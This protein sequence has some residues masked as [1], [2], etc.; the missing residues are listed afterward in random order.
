MQIKTPTRYHFTP[1]RTAIFK[2]RENNNASKD[3]KKL[4]LIAGG[5]Q[6][7]AATVENNI[8]FLKTFL[9]S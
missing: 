6:S 2:K 5:M 8:S 1:P 7:E 9:K 3:V 4:E